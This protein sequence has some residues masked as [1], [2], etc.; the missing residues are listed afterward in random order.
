MRKLWIDFFRDETGVETIEWLAL[1]A[2]AAILIGVVASAGDKVKT[3]LTEI[4]NKL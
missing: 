1:I 2:V 4:V 3:K